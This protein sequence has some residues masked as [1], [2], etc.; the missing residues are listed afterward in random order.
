MSEMFYRAGMPVED[1]CRVCKESRRHTVVVAD[2]EGRPL[3]VVCDSCGST[4]NYRGVRQA[5]KIVSENET[6]GGIVGAEDMSGDLSELEAMIR[7][8]VREECGV[9]P[10][11]L[12][13]KWRGGSVV[14]RPGKEG[15]QEKEL[16][17][18]SFFSK[19]IAVRNRLRVLEQQVNGADIPQDLKL[20]LQGYITG[21]Y[22]SLT[23][24]NVLFADEADRIK[25][26][27]K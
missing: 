13:D 21:A 7:R 23:T 11:A 3:R 4:H 18:E 24:F 8:V 27:G 26:S 6:S 20:K 15:L 22:G 17:L 2:G 10:V 16:P 9:T 5:P 19:I 25:G 1:H 12:A 14:L